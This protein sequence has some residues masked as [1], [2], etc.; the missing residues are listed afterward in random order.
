MKLD[1]CFT[2]RGTPNTELFHVDWP[3]VPSVGDYVGSD[4]PGQVFSGYV[5]I[6]QFHQDEEGNLT[7]E[8][9]IQ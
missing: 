4:K 3:A 6:C 1:I 8:V 5:K 2:E 9:R 7:I